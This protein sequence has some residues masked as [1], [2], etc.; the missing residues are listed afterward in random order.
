MRAFNA[1]AYVGGG[2]GGIPSVWKVEVYGGEEEG[3]KK[4]IIS[5]LKMTRPKVCL[6]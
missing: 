6:L 1:H 2:I 5:D 3:R 4:W